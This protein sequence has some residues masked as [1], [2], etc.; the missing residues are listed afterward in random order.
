MQTDSA[1]PGQQGQDTDDAWWRSGLKSALALPDSV[2]IAAISSH[3]GS[4]A[5]AG[6]GAS[7]ALQSPS[8]PSQLL[9]ASLK[10]RTEYLAGRRCALVALQAA[11]CE[12]A[13]TPEMGEDRLPLWPTDWLGS[14]THSNGVAI[15]AV[16]RRC[17]TRLLGIDV[18]SLIDAASVEGIAALVTLDGEMALLARCG[19]SA[20][21][22]LSLLFSGKE[23]LYK[24]L[25]PDVRRFMDFSA[26][27]AIASTSGA[28]SFV[29]TEDWHPAWPAGSAFSVSYALR[30][31]R[32]YTALH[33]PQ[34]TIL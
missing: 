12:P 28:I 9:H 17:L 21:Q 1:H 31:E 10:R 3:T 6:P 11:G 22:A 16:S 26:A 27:R 5:G 20:S 2:Y 34:A 4:D 13:I 33:V 15:A 8:L 23:S 18:E 14:I 24:A 29:L 19:H 7:V 25:Y 32:V 30:H